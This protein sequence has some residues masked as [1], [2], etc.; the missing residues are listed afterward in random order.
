[1]APKQI[2]TRTAESNEIHFNSFNPGLE[3]T[4]SP[5]PVFSKT[6][7]WMGKYL[8]KSCSF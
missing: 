5:A 2:L 1:M 8:K 7:L 3:Q 4:T 6:K